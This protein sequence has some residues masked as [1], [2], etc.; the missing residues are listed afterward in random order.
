[1]S[2]SFIDYLNSYENKL[3]S[4][5]VKKVPIIS[6]VH[7]QK[8]SKI[9]ENVKV[10]PKKLEQPKTLSV[11]SRCGWNTNTLLEGCQY[12]PRCGQRSLGIASTKC[13]NIISKPKVNESVD[14]A[15][16][17]LDEDDTTERPS[18]I[19]GMLRQ[20]QK[21]PQIL[22]KQNISE[23]Y[24]PRNSSRIS[25]DASDLLDGLPDPIKFI[26][27]PDFN[28]FQNKHLQESSIVSPEPLPNLPQSLP[29]QAIDPDVQRQMEQLGLI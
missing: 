14:Y 25:D 10:S 8:V 9:I 26:P 24:Q 21:V 17:L 11:C 20:S 27:M 5:I 2:E 3:E 4:S 19:E 7:P 23:N 28:Q 6:K 29:S 1:M 15:N 13:N 22:Q 18:M 16:S 12:C